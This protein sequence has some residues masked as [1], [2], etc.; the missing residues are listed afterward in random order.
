MREYNPL[1]IIWSSNLKNSQEFFAVYCSV[2]FTCATYK[3]E[4]G[5]TP[6]CHFALNS[7]LKK[8]I[9]LIFSLAWILWNSILSSYVSFKQFFLFSNTKNFQLYFLT[10]TIFKNWMVM[11]RGIQPHQAKTT[12]IQRTIKN[13]IDPWNSNLSIKFE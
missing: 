3:S 5:S 11:L 9:S 10:F 8:W 13:T 1:I 12:N 2:V 6:A 7:N 4:L